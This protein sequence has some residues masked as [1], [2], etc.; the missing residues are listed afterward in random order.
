MSTAAIELAWD[1][2][3]AVPLGVFLGV[4]SAPGRLAGVDFRQWFKDPSQPSEVADR[5]WIGL[6][7]SGGYALLVAA[8]ITLA[9]VGLAVWF[10]QVNFGFW[11]VG[12]WALLRACTGVA[13]GVVAVHAIAEWVWRKSLVIGVKRAPPGRYLARRATRWL[14]LSALGAPAPRPESGRRAARR[15]IICCDGTW[16]WPDGKHETNVVRLLRAIKP[17]AAGDIQQIVHYHQGVGTGNFLDRLIGGGAGVGLSKSVKACYGFLA[18]NYYPGD[19]QSPGDEIFLFG[20]SRGAYIAR[21]VAGVVGRVGILRK[22][23][24]E[25]F[26]EVWDWY[27]D[28]ANRKQKVLDLLAP[29]RTPDVNIECIGVWDTVGALGIP[30]TRFC[31]QEFAFHETELGPKVRYAFQALAMDERRGNF[32]GAVWVPSDK[33]PPEQ[34]LEQAWFPGSHSN[35]GG[36]CARHGLS[37]T[38]LIW[39]L[40]R[41]QH[42]KLLDLDTAAV[43]AALD[44][45]EPYP[46]GLL[47]NSRTFFWKLIGGSVPRPVGQT[48]ERERIH[49]SA[50]VRSAEVASHSGSDI[51][52]QKRRVAWLKDMKGRELSRTS[53]EL[54]HEAERPPQESHRPRLVFRSCSFCTWIVRLAA[55]RG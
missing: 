13:I 36:G 9:A 34:V 40:T 7:R 51:Y 50:W 20:F 30:G 23:E 24:M 52:K 4:A 35:V 47:E 2:W 46:V 49:E 27:T 8:L 14:A 43:T 6:L 44:A 38:S 15:L 55:G 28:R 26:S 48:F 41:L 54:A 1:M 33:A 3:A 25:R 16:N 18:D 29:N 12:C 21:S 37:D 11:P 10:G 45:R 17:V 19:E 5:S 53:C 22:T 31:A 39:M 42:W 32:Q